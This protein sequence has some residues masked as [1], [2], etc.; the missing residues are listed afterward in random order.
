MNPILQMDLEV[1]NAHAGS[2]SV[3]FPRAVVA[4]DAGKIHVFDIWWDRLPGGGSGGR[5][6]G[7]GVNGRVT[8]HPF[9][10]VIGIVILEGCEAFSEPRRGW[11]L[12]LLV[13]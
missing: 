13:N 10:P 3:Q 9:E 12:L 6:L 8:H 11:W 1:L 7:F 5:E 4:A 2:G